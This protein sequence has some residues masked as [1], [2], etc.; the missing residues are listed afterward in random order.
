MI[1]TW[2]NCQ[3]FTVS[4][5]WLTS[6]QVAFFTINTIRYFC[7]T[8]GLTPGPF[9]FLQL[10]VM[11]CW[12]ITG[13]KVLLL[14]LLEDNIAVHYLVGMSLIYYKTHPFLAIE[15]N[16]W[17][18]IQK[19]VHPS[20]IL[21]VSLWWVDDGGSAHFTSSVSCHVGSGQCLWRGKCV[22][23]V[24]TKLSNWPGK[25]DKTPHAHTHLFTCLFFVRIHIAFRQTFF[26]THY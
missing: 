17:N 9:N 26:I 6:L 15:E 14:S 5:L 18:K 16:D 3:Y 1:V 21:F 25:A 12:P 22:S 20:Y 4:D 24:Q 11:S 8:P 7:D 23:R 10:Q 2:W 19:K 13:Q